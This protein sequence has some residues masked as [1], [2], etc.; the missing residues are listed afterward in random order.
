MAIT[1]N[2]EQI[3]KGIIL[4]NN[5][6]VYKDVNG[7]WIARTE[8]TTCEYQAFKRHIELLDEIN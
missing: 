7:C 6:E 1:V 3:D 4:V 8:L 5:K 2:S